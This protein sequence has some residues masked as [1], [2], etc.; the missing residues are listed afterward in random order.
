MCSI[1]SV[2]VDEIQWM[3]DQGWCPKLNRK[4]EWISDDN[5]NYPMTK[6]P[7]FP[8]TSE[9]ILARL[10]WPNEHLYFEKQNPYVFN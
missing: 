2:P 1:E 9:L 7:K 4:Y 10:G 3:I 5:G 8:V 6:S